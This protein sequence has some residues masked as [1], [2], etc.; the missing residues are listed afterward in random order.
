MSS[1]S[2]SSFKKREFGD[3]DDIDEGDPPSINRTQGSKFAKTINSEGKQVES[4]KGTT[5]IN[6]FAQSVPGSSSSSSSS[7]SSDYINLPLV[8]TGPPAVENL[9]GFNLKPAITSIQNDMK[10]IN[11]MAQEID[12]FT[13]LMNQRKAAEEAGSVDEMA[14]LDQ[15]ISVYAIKNFEEFKKRCDSLAVKMTAI[16]PTIDSAMDD[17][18]S[19]DFRIAQ[20]IK[21]AAD[22]IRAKYGK[23]Y[24]DQ[25]IELQKRNQEAQNLQVPSNIYAAA[26]KTGAATATALLKGYTSVVKTKEKVESEASHYN[27]KLQAMLKR[28]EAKY[29]YAQVGLSLLTFFRACGY[30]IPNPMS[31]FSKKEQYTSAITSQAAP[32]FQEMRMP[33]AVAC[34]EK[35]QCAPSSIWKMNWTIGNILYGAA[36]LLVWA[37]CTYASIGTINPILAGFN[38]G[39]LIYAVAYKRWLTEEQ[40]TNKYLGAVNTLATGYN[41][42]TYLD[43]G[44]T[45]GQM[46]L[47][48]CKF[49][50]D[51]GWKVL[52]DKCGNI[53]GF[54][55]DEG[56]D[57]PD[58]QVAAG[59]NDMAQIAGQKN[60]TAYSDEQIRE[61]VRET[62]RTEN[63]GEPSEAAI[64]ALVAQFSNPIQM[65]TPE[66]REAVGNG[67][68]NMGQADTVKLQENLQKIAETVPQIDPNAVANLEKDDFAAN[69]LAAATAYANMDT[70]DVGSQDLYGY[71]LTSKERD[72]QLEL[73]RIEEGKMA[74]ILKGL[75]R[76]SASTGPSSSTFTGSNTNIFYPRTTNFKNY[77]KKQ[78]TDSIKK[79]NEGIL[80]SEAIPCR[81]FD[82]LK[83]DG[84]T[85]DV[86]FYAKKT[87]RAVN[88]NS[89]SSSSSSSSNQDCP[90]GYT[91]VND[92]NMNKI[93]KMLLNKKNPIL[94]LCLKQANKPCICSLFEPKEEF[95]VDEGDVVVDNPEI[96]PQLNQ[97]IAS[98]V[99]RPENGQKGVMSWIGTKF[100]NG[101]SNARD[102]YEVAGLKVTMALNPPNLSSSNSSNSISAATNNNSNSNSNSIQYSSDTDDAD[103][104]DER[105]I[106]DRMG[107]R[108]KSRRNLKSKS[109]RRKTKVKARMTGGKGTRMVKRHTKK[110][111]KPRQTRKIVRRRKPSLANQMQ[112]MSNQ[113]QQMMSKQQMMKYNQQQMMKYNSNI[114]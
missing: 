54:K 69:S 103:S 55:D 15:K 7:S 89:S 33:E 93:M 71:S 3:I 98:G 73:N 13:K 96:I 113:Q 49:A 101:W 59:L 78:L 25:V 22:E 56:N 114:Y 66:F 4:I 10:T 97:S 74:T 46:S 37:G 14:Y 83:P 99:F 35:G 109:K 1:S 92:G 70:A 87:S 102:L 61:I 91:V 27:A 19:A 32:E 104:E 17:K 81:L 84:T 85:I 44:I 100:S 8:A 65:F 42:T 64:D 88:L 105:R 23:I 18:A 60:Q 21:A 94:K 11:T 80:F 58:D 24:D 34:A 29:E 75:P 5:Q 107:G 43:M 53:I 76:R 112:K 31:M 95:T 26:E 108:R 51:K 20:K 50:Y 30:N 16:K 77:I 67:E 2:N 28:N 82:L 110:S 48:V 36:S 62:I 38:S 106:F 39:C 72:D 45:I 9:P 86:A 47:N 52:F 90:P 40:K 41:A 111:R 68:Y 6:P 12:G 57:I 79:T 63:G